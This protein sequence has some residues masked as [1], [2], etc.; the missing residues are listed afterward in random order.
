MNKGE[1]ETYCY[2]VQRGKP[3]AMVPVQE[4]YLEEVVALV[5]RLPSL[6]VYIERLDKGWATLWIYK[7]PHILEVIKSVPQVPNTVFDHWAL[8]KLF[9]YEEAAILEFI[10]IKHE[11]N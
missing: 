10:E 3:A 5:K 8:G 2:M 1:I 9:G 11:Q 7:Y 4:R 6:K